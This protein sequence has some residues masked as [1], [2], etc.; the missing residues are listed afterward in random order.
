MLVLF[1]DFNGLVHPEFLPQGLTIDVPFVQSNFSDTHG[2][3]KKKTNH[4]H[5]DN[6]LAYTPM[7]VHE[8]AAKQK[9][10]IMPQTTYSPAPTIFFLFSKLKTDKNEI[11]IGSVGDTKKYVSEL[12]WRLKK[13]PASDY[14]EME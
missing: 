14:F 10:V 1:F 9:I 5:H 13:A 8:F 3:V 11:Q 4:F 7:F 12:F 2:I 6:I